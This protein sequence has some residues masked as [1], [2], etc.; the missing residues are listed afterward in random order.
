LA[1]QALS[2][3]VAAKVCCCLLPLI[4]INLVIWHKKELMW[5]RILL[6]QG[7]THHWIIGSQ[8]LRPTFYFHL[9]AAISF[10]MWGTSCAVTHCHIPDGWNRPAQWREKLKT[11]CS[12]IHAL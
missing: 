1:Y 9:V 12:W 7:M 10:I 6:L 8:H 2:I 11:W 3:I 4:E 5:L